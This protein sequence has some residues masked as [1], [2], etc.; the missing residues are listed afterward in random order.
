MAPQVGL[1]PTTLRLTA[2]CS[3]IELLRSVV[4]GVRPGRRTSSLD[5]CRIA[6]RGLSPAPIPARWTL[7]LLWLRLVHADIEGDLPASVGLAAPNGGVASLADHGAGFRDL[8]GAGRIAKAAGGFHDL[9]MPDDAHGRV[10][11]DARPVLAFF[12]FAGDHL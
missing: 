5:Y 11:E 9:G 4:D 7:F 2:G 3:A 1:E 12:L 10:G 8:E 6:L